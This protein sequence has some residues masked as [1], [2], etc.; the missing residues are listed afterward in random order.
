MRPNLNKKYWASHENA[1]SPNGYATATDRKTM[2][3]S[4]VLPSQVIE[5]YRMDRVTARRLAK[6][7]FKCLDE[8][9][10]PRSASK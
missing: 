1:P 2:Q 7:I 4:L 6:A 8:T 3:L 10:E 9:V 5:H